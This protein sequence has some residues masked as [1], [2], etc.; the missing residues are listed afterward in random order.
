MESAYAVGNEISAVTMEC[1]CDCNP[2]GECLAH[3]VEISDD[4]WN[5]ILA[6]CL[7]ELEGQQPKPATIADFERSMARIR[8]MAF[9]GK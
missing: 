4:T 7:I 5:A 3:Q 2:L 1:T 8:V 6:D 9:F